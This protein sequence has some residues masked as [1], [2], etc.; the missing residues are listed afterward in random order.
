MALKCCLLLLL[1]VACLTCLLLA[2]CT[3]GVFSVGRNSDEVPCKVHC[4]AAPC[5]RLWGCNFTRG[6]VASQFF[7]RS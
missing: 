7:T 2:C 1:P 5:T 4:R 3:T 6:A